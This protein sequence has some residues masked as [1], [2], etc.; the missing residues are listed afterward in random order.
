[1]KRLFLYL[2]LTSY[3]TCY[4]QTDRPVKADRIIKLLESLPS[5]NTSNKSDTL[6][7]NLLC[8][9]SEVTTGKLQKVNYL[10]EALSIASDSKNYKLQLNVVLKLVDLYKEQLVR[11]NQYLLQALALAEKV[12]ANAETLKIL[13]SISNSYNELGDHSI[14][15]RYA[16][17]YY[18][19]ALK[20]GTLEQQLLGINSIGT[21]YFRMEDYD[22][23]LKYYEQCQD[24]NIHLQSNKV[25]NAYL[26]NSAMVHS[27]K[28]NYDQ[29][30]ANLTA[31]VSIDDGYA[32]KETF[33]HNELTKLYFLKRDIDQAIK[34]AQIS[35]SSSANLRPIQKLATIETLKDIYKY[36]GNSRQY[37]TYLEKYTDIKLRE[38]STKNAR[39]V[40]FYELRL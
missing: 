19:H 28:M 24:R 2:L 3:L 30:I 38:G 32:D 16:N 5:T 10:Q 14:A 37:T 29:A 23:A 12:S 35:E 9:L 11:K 34:H 8:Q 31:A 40:E 27:R 33:L 21:T 1:M 22:E 26:I 39:L 6:R 18:Q 20:Y 25:K 15:L 4:G 13:S 7:V 17:D 36:T